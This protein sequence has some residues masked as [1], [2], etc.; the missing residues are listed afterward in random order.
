M[1]LKDTCSLEEKPRQHIRKQRHYFADKGPSSQRYSFSSSHIWVWEL[2]YKESWAPKNWCFWT[3]VLEETLES[4]VDCKEIQP[5]NPKGNQS[6][7][8]IGRT[9]AEAELQ[10]CGHLMW[11]TDSYEKTLMLG[12]IEGRRRKVWQLTRLL[13]GITDSMNMSLSKLREL[14]MGRETVCCS[15]WGCKEWYMTEWLNWTELSD[16]TT[17]TTWVLLSPKP[18]LFPLYNNRNS[19]NNINSRHLLSAYHMSKSV[20]SIMCE[21]SHLILKTALWNTS[22]YSVIDFIVEASEFTV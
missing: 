2:D 13:D 16:W 19:D 3:V 10:Y 15:P 7:I 17:A 5:V 8:I 14:V 12:K 18:I 22:Y 21:L 20:L 11:R 9:D 6:W 1:K 4:P